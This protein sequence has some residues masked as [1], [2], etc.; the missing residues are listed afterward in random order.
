[1]IENF[2]KFYL[3]LPKELLE[4]SLAADYNRDTRRKLNRCKKIET[5]IKN[6]L[7]NKSTHNLFIESISEYSEF[8]YDGYGGVNEVIKNINDDNFVQSMVYMLKNYYSNN[9]FKEYILSDK[10]EK[11]LKTFDTL[12]LDETINNIGIKEV[13]NNVNKTKMKIDTY[14]VYIEEKNGHYNIYPLFKFENNQLIN[15]EKEEYPDYGNIT[16]NP[17]AD[18]LKQ[19]YEENSLWVCKFSQKQLEENN[20]KSSNDKVTKFKIDGNELIKNKGICNFNDAGLYEI[21]ELFEENN[22]IESMLYNTNEI[23][24]KSKPIWNKIYIKDNEYIY[25]PFGYIDNKRGGGYLLE[26]EKSNYSIEKYSIKNNESKMSF[27]EIDNKYDYNEMSRDIVYFYDEENLISKKIDIISDEELIIKLKEAIS[28]KNTGYSRKEVQKIKGNIK[29]LTC[30]LFSKERQERIQK[31]IENTQ[32]TDDFIENDLMSIVNLLLDDQNTKKDIADKILK[33][34]DILRKLQNV[35]IVETRVNN[36]KEELEKLKQ[37]IEEMKKEEEDIKNKKEKDFIKTIEVNIQGKKEEEQ[38]LKN[39]IEKLKAQYKSYNNFIDL[40]IKT[41]KLQEEAEEA[42]RGYDVFSQHNEKIQTEIKKKIDDITSVSN[43]S[44]IAFDGMIANEILEAAAKWNKS[45]Y[46][47]E[48]EKCIARKD[49]VDKSLQIKS[50]ENEKIIDYI[51]EQIKKTRNYSKNDVVNIMICLTQEFLTVFAGEPGVGKTSIC[52]IIAKILGLSNKDDNYN[53][54]TEISVEKGW[55]SKRDLIGYYNP[56]TKSFD[57]NNQSLFKA[58]N[59]LDKE[60]CNAVSDFP[61]Y[62]LLDEANLSSMEHY[63]ADF[64]NVCD[65]DKENRKINLG[66][67]Y[68]YELPQTLRFLATINYDHTTETLSPRLID[69]AWIILLDR[70]DLENDKGNLYNESL[71]EKKLDN[72][73]ILYEDLKKCFLYSSYK[74]LEEETNLID[75]VLKEIYKIFDDNNIAISQRVDTMINKYLRV[76]YNLFDKTEDTSSEFIALDYAVAQKLLPKINGYGDD[77]EKFLKIL[78][79]KFN[80]NNMMKSQRIVNKILKK[81]ATNMQYYQFFS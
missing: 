41:K 5:K 30:N 67:D 58:F 49:F 70:N 26:K 32:R 12:E 43:Y 8:N 42:K 71:E 69:R 75:E 64:M 38:E 78:E 59:I 25:G 63:W 21:I 7:E 65:L 61:Y 62:I 27:L 55:S 74:N 14:V 46:V 4:K 13:K 81:G 54:F 79:E 76:G 68:I 15:I 33:D 73:I 50:F 20:Q 80:N 51:Y 2:K 66:E 52:N 19:K 56:L 29:A 77:Y 53:R 31:F 28:I 9:D 72:D 16:V 11:N 47:E 45:K 44:D 17:R 34:N 35:E 57:K 23:R 37:E 40:D 22:D 36:K 18:F 60:Y 48:F 10:F 3:K 1:M 39:S 24:L 6:I